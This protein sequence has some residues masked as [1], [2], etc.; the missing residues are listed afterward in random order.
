M[1][2]NGK[3]FLYYRMDTGTSYILI[4]TEFINLHLCFFGMGITR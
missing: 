2:H 1:T 3:V 4:S